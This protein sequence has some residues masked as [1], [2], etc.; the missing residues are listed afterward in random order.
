MGAARVV[1]LHGPR[2]SGKT[3]LARR[4]ARERDGHYV[5]LD[6]D[7][8]LALALDD[9]HTFIRAFRYPLVIDEVQ[10]AGDRLVRAVKVA[11]DDGFN[12][13]GRYLLTGSSNFLTVPTISESLAG[14]AVILTLWPFSQCERRG[15]HIDASRDEA[16]SGIAGAQ[17][18]RPR[19]ASQTAARGGTTTAPSVVEEW[20]DN[21][22]SLGEARRSTTSRRDYLELLCVG[23]FA[24]VQQLSEHQRRRW[25]TNYAD[26]VVSRDIAQLGDIRRSALLG[27]MLRLAAAETSAELNVTRWSQRLG[28][29]RATVQSYLGWLR[30]VFAISELPSWRRN[31]SSRVVQRPKLHM[32]DSGLAAALAGADAAALAAPSHPMTGALLETFAANEIMRMNSASSAQ[33]LLHH[34]RDKAGREVDLVIERAD[35]AIVAVEVKATSSPRADDLRHLGY[36]RDRLDASQPGAFRAGVLLHTGANSLP[37]GD[38]LYSAATDTLWAHQQ[39]RG[40]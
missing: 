2:Q 19:P 14:R 1:V 22:R 25:F 6:D 16:A 7:D 39:T 26:T 28:A 11:A 34:Y 31:R 36:L 23:G 32:T 12:Q 5:A 10:R 30:T 8:S 24:E 4:Y 17:G 38:R 29:D 27:P 3:T 9:P 35:G 18:A 40:G 21:P 15:T 37:L 13:T 33:F 20:F